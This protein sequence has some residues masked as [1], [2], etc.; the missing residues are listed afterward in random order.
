MAFRIGEYVTGG[1]LG[2]LRRNSIF[3]WIEFA[4][5]Y[6]VRIELTGNFPEELA[7]KKIRFTVPKEPLCQP[8]EFPE[9]IEKLA[10]RQI[11]VIGDV[12]LRHV[13]VPDL[14]IDE[15]Y[16]LD[17]AAQQEHTHEKNSLYLE[18]Y[19]QN[20]RVVAELVDPSIEI[21]EEDDGKLAGPEDFMPLPAEPTDGTTGGLEITEIRTD[22]DG[23]THIEH[24][25]FSTAKEDAAEDDE[26]P[27]HLFAPGLEQS[28][29]ESLGSPS[30][31]SFSDS[32][33]L[34]EGEVDAIPWSPEEQ[35]QPRSWDEV[36]P[37]IDPE[38]KA[39]YEQWDEIFHQEKDE[40]ITD[41]IQST[42]KLPH[43]EDV[44]SDEEAEPLVMAILT[45]LA[46]LS[47]A[48]NVCEHFSPLDTY[49]LLMNEILP[50]AT[51]HPNLAA[52]DIVQ[53]FSTSDDCHACQAEFDVEYEARYGED[54]SDSDP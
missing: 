26:D 17:K 45:Q 1:E 33:S 43:A 3:G 5:D 47:V 21:L 4:P 24:Y 12:V 48:M 15:F 9:A 7:G 53:H 13:K 22:E 39:I 54:S 35:P 36:I 30:P 23:E 51:A 10:D 42:L 41:L 25:N 20:G 31:D 37:G 14:P 38:T 28:V 34:T 27:Y 6:G 18:W 49:R 11:G 8:G 32:D 52:T 44:T 46:L 19:S 29:A 2:N 16:K 40:P 50:T